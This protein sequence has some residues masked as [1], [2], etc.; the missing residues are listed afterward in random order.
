M[1]ILI[2]SDM[3]GCAGILNYEDWCVRGGACFERGQRLLT[4]E[5]NAA[6]EGFAAGGATEI[7]VVDGHGQGGLAPEFLDARATLVHGSPGRFL[8][9]VLDRTFDALAFVGQHAK[10]GTPYSHITHT[11]WFNFI[12]YTINGISVGEYGEWALAAGELGVPTIFAAGEE[13][14]AREAEALTPGVVTVA[15]KRGL[16]PDGLDHLDTN[17]YRQAKLAA[18]HLAPARARDLI[19]AGA[20]KAA[21][22]RLRSRRAFRGPALKPPYVREVRLR[23]NPNIHVPAYSR[24]DEHPDSI[25]ELIN[26]R[27]RH[28]SEA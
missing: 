23:P 21:R 12:D 3:E 5:I 14:L 19:R 7:A 8:P 24:R 13:A 6:V 15:V 1:K 4:E 25:I 27:I 17:Q 16:L 20:R 11:G 28:P 10:A 2:I 18:W 26:I 9:G 22:K